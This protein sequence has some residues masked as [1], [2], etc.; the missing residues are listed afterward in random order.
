VRERASERARERE[1]ERET[2]RERERDRERDRERE[3]EREEQRASPCRILSID[4]IMRI[5]SCCLLL[6]IGVAETWRRA[7]K[8]AVKQQYSSSE[9]AVQQQ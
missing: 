1:R 7:S 8:A 6:N 5:F 2:D 9:A 3:R 4:S